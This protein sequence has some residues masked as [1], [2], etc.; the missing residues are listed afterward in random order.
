MI[1][2]EIHDNGVFS[3]LFRYPSPAS[4]ADLSIVIP[5]W[6]RCDRL[7]DLLNYLEKE[8]ASCSDLVTRI[9]FYVID[10]A[11]EDRTKEIVAQS[12]VPII[13]RRH[14]HNIGGDKNILWAYAEPKTPYAWVIGDDDL[15]NEGA[16]LRTIDLLRE[17]RPGL[18]VLSHNKHAWKRFGK[19][20]A[21][22]E[23]LNYRDFIDNGFISEF[24]L[25]EHSLIS[26]NIVHLGNFDQALDVSIQPYTFYPHMYAISGGLLKSGES[27]L[28]SPDVIF[29]GQY[30]V[31]SDD[32]FDKMYH[33]Y[34]S[35]KNRIKPQV[36]RSL[37]EWYAW[38]LLQTEHSFFIAFAIAVLWRI[39]SG[40]TFFDANAAF[41][42]TPLRRCGDILCRYLGKLI[43][44]ALRHRRQSSAR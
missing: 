17:H 42:L 1:K 27:V 6:N 22:H 13:Y 11:S 3:D 10:N 4:N 32:V 20:Y 30:V 31:H 28:F 18:L 33:Q 2:L 25:M 39:H 26:S 9:D 14:D 8:L 29:N 12:K 41:A 38:V 43:C 16:L 19:D 35:H 36:T 34:N 24:A 23:F 7:A 44:L 37:V 40:T 5:T 21:G 15:P